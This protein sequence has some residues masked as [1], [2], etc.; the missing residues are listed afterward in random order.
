MQLE[1]P[2]G[3]QSHQFGNVVADSG[4]QHD[5][6]LVRLPGEM[7]KSQISGNRLSSKT[8]FCCDH[9]LKVLLDLSLL[10]VFGDAVDEQGALDLQ[11]TQVTSC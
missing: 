11:D 3:V 9:V 8:S 6:V 1:S 7:K 10:G 2:L 5:A 4:L